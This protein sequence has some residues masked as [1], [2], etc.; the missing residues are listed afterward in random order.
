MFSRLL[1]KIYTLR[2]QYR[3]D[4]FA[5]HSVQDC[6]LLQQGARLIIFDLMMGKMK[7][8]TLNCFSLTYP[9]TAV[10][11]HFFPQATTKTPSSSNTHMCT[12][13]H[14]PVQSSLFSPLGLSLLFFHFLDTTFF[15]LVSLGSILVMW[16][17]QFMLICYLVWLLLS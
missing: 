2:Q 3:N 13:T 6:L 15:F 11:C 5:L 9:L 7:G 17:Q 1:V 4:S 10:T 16:S 8:L 12:R 14:T